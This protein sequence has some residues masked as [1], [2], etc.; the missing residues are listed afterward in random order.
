[1][2]SNLRGSLSLKPGSIVVPIKN[3][4]FLKGEETV[5]AE[6]LS[7]KPTFS[8]GYDL[9]PFLQLHL[10]IVS[11]PSHAVHRPLHEQEVGVLLEGEPTWSLLSFDRLCRLEVHE[12][13]LA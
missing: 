13:F 6:L 2:W 7:I 3:R 8:Q 11:M 12:A 10:L 9:S 1:M 4:R 5:F